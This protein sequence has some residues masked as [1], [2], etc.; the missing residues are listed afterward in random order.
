MIPKLLVSSTGDRNV[1]SKLHVDACE[2]LPPLKLTQIYQFLSKEYFTFCLCYLTLAQVHGEN[3][4]TT[5]DKVCSFC[6]APDTGQWWV[7]WPLYECQIRPL[8]CGVQFNAVLRIG[9]IRAHLGTH[10]KQSGVFKC[11]YLYSCQKYL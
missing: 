5:K 11:L 9:E 4:W 7:A 3:D 1:L 10:F 2:H 6:A 8:Y